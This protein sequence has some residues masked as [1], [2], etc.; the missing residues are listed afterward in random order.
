MSGRGEVLEALSVEL[1][2]AL[3]GQR[4]VL[5]KPNFAINT[6]VAYNRLKES[7]PQFMNL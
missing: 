2:K 5:F 7:R 6:A 1:S 4:V 3:R